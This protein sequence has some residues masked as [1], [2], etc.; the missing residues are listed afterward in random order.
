MIEFSNCR[1]VLVMRGYRVPPP[2][3]IFKFKI[4]LNSRKLASDIAFEQMHIIILN[5]IRNVLTTMEMYNIKYLLNLYICNNNIR[6]KGRA[7]S[8]KQKYRRS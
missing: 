2:Q 3:R 1:N 7:Y 8:Q 4:T 6:H 5:E